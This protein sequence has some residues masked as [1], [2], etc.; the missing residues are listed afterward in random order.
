MEMLDSLLIRQL[1]LLDQLAR[2]HSGF[3][4]LCGLSPRDWQLVV[5]NGFGDL[6]PPYRDREE[7]VFAAHHPRR[8]R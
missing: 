8:P 6:F 5:R 3:V 7:A 1:A 2:S 4:R